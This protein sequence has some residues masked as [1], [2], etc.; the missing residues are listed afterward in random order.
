MA[1]LLLVRRHLRLSGCAVLGRP[2]MVGDFPVIQ[3]PDA[4]DQRGVTLR[5]RPIDCF[6]LCF[7]SAELMV[8]MVFDRIILNG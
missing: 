2:P 1:R 3:M 7:E 5:M 8:R 6:F 4:S